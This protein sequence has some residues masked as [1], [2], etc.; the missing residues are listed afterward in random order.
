MWGCRGRASLSAPPVRWPIRD[1][2]R[3]PSGDGPVPLFKGVKSWPLT[4]PLFSTRDQVY[5]L[6]ASACSLQTHTHTRARPN[7]HAKHITTL[8]SKSNIW[9]PFLVHKGTKKHIVPFLHNPTLNQPAV[10]NI[11]LYI[12]VY[13]PK[14]AKVLIY[15][16]EIYAIIK[17]KLLNIINNKII[18]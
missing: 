5:E 16:R 7:T 17:N 11:H 8:R 13:T 9:G 1:R 4:E 3:I 15:L 10:P 12:I 18:Y 14:Y 6:H 2:S